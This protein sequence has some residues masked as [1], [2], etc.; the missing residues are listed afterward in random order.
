M[1]HPPRLLTSNGVTRPLAEWA[2]LIGV[3][4]ETIRVRLDRLGWDV[5]RAVTAFPDKR[6]RRG[7]RHR[8]DAPRPVPKM[9]FH[10]SS[11]KARA[12]WRSGKR[13]HTVYLGDWGSRAAAAAYQRFVAEWA[14]GKYDA[15]TLPA[16]GELLVCELCARRVAFAD[17]EFRKGDRRTSEYHCQRVAM[18]PLN[19]LYGD[20]PAAEFTPDKLKAVR[21]AFI[22]AGLAR[23]SVNHHTSRIV[24][25]FGWAAG[26]GWIPA[27]VPAAL[28]EVKWI[29]AGRTTAPERQRRQPVTEADFL[30]ILPFLARTIP[31][32]V[33]VA[34]ALEVQRL[35][36]MRPVEVCSL[37]PC[38]VDRSGDVWLYTVPDLAN[39][40]FHRDRP[41]WYW[42]GPKAQTHLAPYLDGPAD[43]PAFRTLTS[44]Y[45]LAVRLACGRA[46]VTP[47]TPHQ[48]RHTLA[49]DVARATGDLRAAAAA[50]GDTP[51]TAAKHYVAIDPAERAKIEWARE[52]G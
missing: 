34:A 4:P 1:P 11:G 6:F 19:E 41:Q 35:T 26:E 17:R 12:C 50:I 45:S 30:A 51:E 5:A 36:G 18:R 33:R 49:T 16:G 52:R 42:L 32:A 27:S 40:N 9:A 8:A 10:K 38:D 15:G 14:A 44:S 37:R 47:W 13:H 25:I 39:K 21:T 29:K 43:R 22:D 23:S 31:R 7:G 28:R 24:A 20:I 3:S 48:L 2:E 46:G